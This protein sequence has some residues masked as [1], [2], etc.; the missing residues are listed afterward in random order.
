MGW[1]PSQP[2][3]PAD[4]PQTVPGKDL[5]RSDVDREPPGGNE[6]GVRGQGAQARGRPHR[7]LPTHLVTSFSNTHEGGVA[8]IPSSQ[9]GKLRHQPCWWDAWVSGPR[10]CQGLGEPW[11]E[12]QLLRVGAGHTGKLPRS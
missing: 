1:G 5:L 2:S 11:K 4:R 12:T 10:G 6:V 9:A 7:E 3:L 8:L